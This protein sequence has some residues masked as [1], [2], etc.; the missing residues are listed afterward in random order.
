[1]ILDFWAAAR[2]KDFEET[3]HRAVVASY[4]HFRNLF[5]NFVRDGQNRGDFK[6]T[7]DAEALAA[8][9]V[10]TVD[11]LGIQLFFDRSLDPHRI[12]KAFGQLLYQS[13]KTES[14]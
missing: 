5:T 14:P 7:V 11:G 13:L 9:V 1:V 4:T 8:T 3:Y 12:T 6:Q 10:A 2:G